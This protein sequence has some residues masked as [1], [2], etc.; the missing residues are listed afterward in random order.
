MPAFA[1]QLARV[2]AVRTRMFCVHA[3]RPALDLASK[4]VRRTERRARW[5]HCWQCRRHSE[6][7][8]KTLSKK[9]KRLVVALHEVVFIF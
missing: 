1:A 3:H 7:D 5:L 4:L 8:E 2:Q 9:P 6:R